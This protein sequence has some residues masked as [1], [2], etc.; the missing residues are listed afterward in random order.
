MRFP[1]PG[2]SGERQFTADPAQPQYTLG[3]HLVSRHCPPLGAHPS[4]VCGVVYNGERCRGSFREIHEGDNNNRELEKWL[5]MNDVESVSVRAG[6]Q[7]A[8]HQLKGL[9]GRGMVIR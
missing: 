2:S 6:C 7:L 3:S 4:D 1:A 8:A 5:A 9:K